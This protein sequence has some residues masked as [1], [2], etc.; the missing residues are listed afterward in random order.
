MPPKSICFLYVKMHFGREMKSGRHDEEVVFSR[1]TTW[2]RAAREFV[3]HARLARSF[4]P[5]NRLGSIHR[6][7]DSS[8][9]NVTPCV[10]MPCEKARTDPPASPLP[11][12]HPAP[13]PADRHRSGRPRIIS[14]PDRD[15]ELPYTVSRSSRRKLSTGSHRM[16]S[17]RGNQGRLIANRVRLRHKWRQASSQLA[18]GCVA[19]GVGLR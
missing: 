18:S 2:H 19:N 17:S 16:V 12:R 1:H 15:T 6:F 7:H 5:R 13:A 8:E 9:V 10:R 14:G 4:Q 11:M 3:R